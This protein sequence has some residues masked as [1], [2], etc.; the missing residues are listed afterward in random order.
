MKLLAMLTCV[1][2]SSLMFSCKDDGSNSQPPF[3][4]KKSAEVLAKGVQFNSCKPDHDQVQVYDGDQFTWSIASAG[5][6]PDTSSYEIVF[7]GRTP[8]ASA[9]VNVTPGNPVVTKIQKDKDCVPGQ[10]PDTCYYTYLLLQS[11]PGTTGNV[12]CPDPGIHIIPK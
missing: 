10:K 5:G 3:A 9:S 11:R 12:F 2:L 8:I 4:K 6:I 7:A 1:I